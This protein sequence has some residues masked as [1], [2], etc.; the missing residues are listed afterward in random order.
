MPT[1]AELTRTQDVLDELDNARKR[2][3]L[4]QIVI[5]PCP[6]LLTRL[7]SV[8]AEAEPDLNEVARIATSD[9]AMSACLLRASNGALYASAP[10]AQT[11]GQAMNR[12]GLKQTAAVMT[13]FL[14]QRAIKV[15]APQL[16]RFWERSTK[17]A[18]AMAFM[19]GR[20]PGMSEDLAHT[21]GLFCHVGI[22]VMVQSMRGYTG[23]M[24]EAAARIDRSYIAT[25]NANHRTDHAVVGALVAR[26][27]RLSPTV[28]AAIR[29]HHDLEALGETSADPEV[30]TLIAV[31]LLADFLMRRHEGLEEEAD[32]RNHG[33]AALEWLQA[34]GDDLLLWEDE[35]KDTLDSV[36]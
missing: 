13:G 26:T 36:V 25:E 4:A 6:Q 5:P 3:V 27:W 34:S 2:G 15:N 20:L 28:A 31:G 10:P 23:T 18:Q 1:A 32:W 16:A 24:A 33:A 21:Y 35:L 30:N 17:R 8:M 7:Q 14:A 11:I 9:V 29:L 12:L 19:A 22:P